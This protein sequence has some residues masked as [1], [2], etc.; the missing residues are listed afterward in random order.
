MNILPFQS[1]LFGCGHIVTFMST[2]STLKCD[3][4]YE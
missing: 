3:M 1:L 2:N 4:G